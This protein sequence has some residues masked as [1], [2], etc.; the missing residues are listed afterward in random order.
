MGCPY[1]WIWLVWLSVKTTLDIKDEL[2]ARAKQLAKESGRPLRAI[3]EDGLRAT[4]AAEEQ[5]VSYELLDCSFGN[6]NGD[7][8]LE[9]LSWQDLRQEIYGEP[10]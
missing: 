10:R 7:D 8:P 1:I 2:L 4:L 3:V 5:S 6:A 9:L